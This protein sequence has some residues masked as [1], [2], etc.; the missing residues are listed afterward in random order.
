MRARQ[1]VPPETFL[2]IKEQ[3]LEECGEV[4]VRACRLVG[5][6]RQQASLTCFVGLDIAASA[7]ECTPSP[8]EAALFAAHMHDHLA[9]FLKVYSRKLELADHDCD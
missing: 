9:Q 5:N 3:T 6:G 1:P 8:E 7:L 2:S 4:I